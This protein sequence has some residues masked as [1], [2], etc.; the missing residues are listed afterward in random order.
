MQ[1]EVLPFETLRFSAWNKHKRER[2]ESKQRLIG[3]DT[4]TESV[5]IRVRPSLDGVF[6]GQLNLDD[7]LDT[8]ISILPDNAFAMLMLVE[9]DL[10]ED[11]DDDFCCGRAYGGSRV[12]VVSMAR[13]NPG[14]DDSHNIER[15]HAWPASHCTSYVQRCCEGHTKP[16]PFSKA[17][18]QKV[19]VKASS[20][21]DDPPNSVLTPMGAAMAA[22]KG[23]TKEASDLSG[24]WLA[25]VCQT[26]SHELGHCF[27]IDHCVYYA[28]VMQSTFSLAEDI[29]QP[30]YLCPIDLTKLLR[31]TN[32]DE[33]Q[34]YL[35]LL[36][37]C[38]MHQQVPMFAAFRAWLRSRLAQLGYDQNDVL[39]SKGSKD[40]PI[41]L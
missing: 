33:G 34:R 35:A 32:V 1:I 15:Q 8:A 13:Y 11:E 30:P 23:K 24:L 9:H 36:T 40:W 41:E 10:F 6:Q 25:R 17:V 29:R 21:S 3:L 37:F 38:E 4:A 7:L 26:A 2:H 19:V 12:A 5:G 27:G 39:P 31:A 16:K 18:A 20:S 14:L 28:C 22:Y